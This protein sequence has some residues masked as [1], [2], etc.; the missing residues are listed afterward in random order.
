M[1]PPGPACAASA[2]ISRVQSMVS[3]T[4][5]SG[6][7]GS[8]TSRP[9]LSQD[10]AND[11]GAMDSIAPTRSETLMA[12]TLLPILVSLRRGRLRLARGLLAADLR[13]D[14]HPVEAAPHEED[15]HGETHR[16]D[17]GRG[18]ARDGVRLVVRELD[19]QETEEGRELDDRVHRD[20]AGVLEWIA[21]RVA[22]D[23]RV[24]QR[25]ALLLQLDLDDLLGVVPGAAGVRHEQGLEEAEERDRDQVPDEEERV[26]E[27]ERQGAE[28]DDQEDVEHSLLRVRRADLDDL[29]AVGDRRLGRSVQLDVRLDVLDRAV[30]AGA[31]GLRAGAREPV[32]DRAAGD[33]AEQ[34]RRGGE[35]QGGG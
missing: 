26:E 4:R 29:L 25:R 21:N 9:T 6:A 12:S 31:H 19:G 34:E 3:S 32:D 33:E 13:V 5:D 10:A 8:P 24:V 2:T 28:E 27:R 18:L 23:A 15:H 20:A 1:A 35:G 16:R 22:D 11:V 30:R 17:D 7:A 14:A